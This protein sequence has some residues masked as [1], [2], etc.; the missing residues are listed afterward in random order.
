MAW[1][2]VKHR[3]NFTFTFIV[4]SKDHVMTCTVRIAPGVS[5]VGTRQVVRPASRLYLYS[6]RNRP[7]ENVTLVFCIRG[8]PQ[9]LQGNAIVKL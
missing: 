2:L 3:D 5:A 1:C 4:G 9:S 6:Y 8:L 7:W